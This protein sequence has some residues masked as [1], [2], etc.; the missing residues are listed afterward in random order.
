MYEIIL[1]TI[2]ARFS[3]SALGIRYLRA[4]LLELRDKCLIQEF[5]LE[6]RPIDIVEKLIQ[7]NPKIIGFSI[8]IWNSLQI[9]KIIKLIRAISPKTIIIVGGPEVSFET[10][11]NQICKFVDYTITGYAEFNFYN[12]CKDLFNHKI[13]KEKIIQGDILNGENL[14]KIIFPINEYSDFDLKNR[15]IYFEASR[16]C[17]FKCEFCLSSLDAT[18]VQFPPAK[19]FEYLNNLWQR[20]LRRFKFV[21]RTFNIKPKNAGQ[22]LDFFIEKLP[23]KFFLHI[24]M[25]PDILPNN[26]RKRL[27]K[28]P[29]GSL[30]LEIGIQSINPNTQELISR[31]QDN[32]KVIENLQFL[33]KNTNAHLH[34]DL[35]VGLP[36]EDI[37]NFAQS[38]N[39]LFSLGVNEIQIGILKKLPGAPIA[40]H[41]NSQQMVFNC[42]PP[43]EIL[44]NKN[45]S[46]IQMQKLKR[47][48]RYWDLIGNSGKFTN[49][50]SWLIAKDPFN[51]FLEISEK[52][53]QLS[54][55]TYKIRL[56]RLFELF[57][58]AG[59]Q[60]ID[61]HQKFADLL[62]SDYQKTGSQG[63]LNFLRQNKIF[64]VKR[65]RQNPIPKRQIQHL[66]KQ[67]LSKYF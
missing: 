19:I 47:F 66:R 26:I 34:T 28:F 7:Y 17:P 13:P 24:E 62:L 45:I 59:K 37:E 38:F 49:S 46:F 56:E 31:K 3:H 1:T 12:L 9:L 25:V 22:L 51:L 67:E 60:M 14:A 11:Q 43:Y 6:D 48:S 39:F 15:H 5:T 64:Q 35:I 4:N 36:N 8:Y 44:S 52:I 33:Q 32:E 53:Y 10:D 23:E 18:S 65:N 21:D 29:A 16:G 57:F 41:I 58:F 20:G 50:L 61:N 27:K 40:R 30:Q 54:N 2:N 42:E 63:K 55:Q